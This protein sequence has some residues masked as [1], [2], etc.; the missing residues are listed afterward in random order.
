MLIFLNKTLHFSINMYS[1]DYMH[2]IQKRTIQTATTSIRSGN[3]SSHQ[4]ENE[5]MQGKE[6]NKPSW[7]HTI[8]NFHMQLYVTNFQ[9]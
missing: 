5:A 6:V 9:I 8:V 7:P 4:I 1:N 3:Q 2:F